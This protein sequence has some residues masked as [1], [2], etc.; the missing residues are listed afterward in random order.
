V[1]LGVTAKQFRRRLF[2]V[3]VKGGGTIDQQ[4]ERAEQYKKRYPFRYDLRFTLGKHPPLY[5][6]TTLDI[7]KDP[8][9]STIRVV[10]L[11]YEDEKL[12]RDCAVRT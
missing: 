8:F 12:N 9:Y 3:F 7:A 5:A 1:E 10:K 11:K 2:Q 6:E 4:V